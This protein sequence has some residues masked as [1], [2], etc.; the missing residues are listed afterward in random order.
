MVNIVALHSMSRISSSSPLPFPTLGH[1]FESPQAEAQPAAIGHQV[2]D[3]WRTQSGGVQRE[4]SISDM[5]QGEGQE[6]LLEAAA[7]RIEA[8][9]RGMRERYKLQRQRVAAVTIEK[10][11]RGHSLRTHASDRLPPRRHPPMPIR[12]VI[13]GCEWS[14]A[15]EQARTVAWKLPAP[16]IDFVPALSF[17]GAKSVERLRPKLDATESWVLNAT[18]MSS[19]AECKALLS[20]PLPPTHWVL[21]TV[22]D[23]IAQAR[24]LASDGRAT[25]RDDFERTWIRERLRVWKLSMIDIYTANSANRFL[26][27]DTGLSSPKDARNEILQVVLTSLPE[28]KL[29]LERDAEHDSAHAAQLAEAIESDSSVEPVGGAPLYRWDSVESILNTPTELD[30]YASSGPSDL[31]FAS[32]DRVE[33]ITEDWRAR[34]ILVRLSK[35]SSSFVR[36]HVALDGRLL[37]NIQGA[38][39]SP[40]LAAQSTKNISLYCRANI[41]DSHGLPFYEVKEQCTALAYGRGHIWWNEELCF[42]LPRTLL[43][44]SDLYMQLALVNESSLAIACAKRSLAEMAAQS[45]HSDTW[46]QLDEDWVLER[47]HVTTDAQDLSPEVA[48]GGRMRVRSQVI[49]LVSTFDELMRQP[50][51]EATVSIIPTAAAEPPPSARQQMH[52]VAEGIEQLPTNAMLETRS[53]SAQTDIQGFQVEMALKHELAEQQLTSAQRTSEGGK[54]GSTNKQEVP[55]RVRTTSAEVQTGVVGSQVEEALESAAALA[56]IEKRHC[57]TQTTESGLAKG[58]DKRRGKEDHA[59]EVADLRQQLDDVHQDREASMLLLDAEL[60][61]MKHLLVKELLLI[62][63]DLNT[64]IAAVG[65]PDSNTEDASADR[66]K[67]PRARL[68]PP[69]KVMPHLKQQKWNQQKG[70]KRDAAAPPQKKPAPSKQVVKSQPTKGKAAPSSKPPASSKPKPQRQG[71]RPPPAVKP[72]S[73]AGPT[74]Q[75]KPTKHMATRAEAVSASNEKTRIPGR[76]KLWIDKPK[77]ESPIPVPI[78]SRGP[79]DPRPVGREGRLY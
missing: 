77:A 62:E 75:G 46:P 72:K 49:D 22:D 66:P 53:A 18:Q 7:A 70:S 16:C 45:V 32:L 24:A 69:V 59:K 26:R 56:M 52:D 4:G 19:A 74:V 57:S 78:E 27:V 23:S 34:S 73:K 33:D 2:S 36:R 15:S 67:R 76:R 11:H 14:G 3:E 20:L 35:F 54:H 50:K 47:G 42:V 13:C 58:T 5:L 41:V 79:W 12:I 61:A 21:C 6:S 31:S 9:Q 30:D 38:A 68:P 10:M 48:A 65:L 43:R 64:A 63:E 39:L 44:R 28:Y 25:D 71:P 17:D 8:H 29:G 51:L 1:S 40:E 60:R 37:I 55:V